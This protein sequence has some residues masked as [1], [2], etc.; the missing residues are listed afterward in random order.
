MTKEK[1]INQYKGKI[2]DCDILLKSIKDNVRKLRHKEM[3]TDEKI[4]E[5]NYFASDRKMISAQ[6]QC[7]VQFISDIE[8]E[9]D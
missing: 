9:L 4:N 3:N 1:L 6:R 7:Y 8:Y 2:E 5:L